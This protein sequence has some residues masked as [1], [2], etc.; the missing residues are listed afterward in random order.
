MGVA[1]RAS[2]SSAA[3]LCLNFFL[4][5]SSSFFH[6]SALSAILSFNVSMYC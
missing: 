4:L 3:V 5:L 2:L 1:Q 6:F